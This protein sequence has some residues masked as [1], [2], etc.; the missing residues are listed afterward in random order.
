MK[1]SLIAALGV[2]L[3][4]TSP[5]F[6]AGDAAAG[7]TK[8]AV[9]AGCHGA[10][11]KSIAPNFPHIGG[12]HE[13]YLLKQLKAFKSG[14][15]EDASMAPMVAP[16]NDQDMADLAAYFAAKPAVEGV[17]KEEN[18]A[19]GESIYRGGITE[20]KVA[21]CLACH[22]PAGNGNPGAV[23]PA[24][25]GQTATYTAKALK[26]FR[27][28]ARTTDPNSMMRDVAKRM[29]DAEIAA[30]ANYIEGLH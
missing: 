5:S 3:S 20:T 17:A 10:E 21:A 9:C 2:A 26:D 29:T 11:G 16:L 7:A 28:G 19:L 6:A 27:S 18:L 15:R 30:V 1:K 22:G 14:E 13:S 8:S 25:S 4:M 23:Y 24:L 12:Q